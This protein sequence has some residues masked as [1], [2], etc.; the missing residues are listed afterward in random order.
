M[1]IQAQT[2]KLND[3]L[4]IGAVHGD[5]S[6]GV[7]ILKTIAKTRNDF[8]WIIGSPP[9][10]QLNQREF[11]GDLNRSAPGDITS[12]D[13]AKKRAA[14]LITLSKKFRYTIDLHGSTQAVGIF[15]IITKLT[16]QNLRLATMLDV[17]R[18]VLWPALSSEMTGPL[19]EYFPCGVE[20]EC[21][22]KDN[23]AIQKDLQKILET[24]MNKLEEKE[25]LDWKSA[26]Q[27]RKLYK[28]IGPIMH[29][30]ITSPKVLTEFKSTTISGKTISPVFIGSYTYSNIAAYA[31]ESITPQEA[32]T[33]CI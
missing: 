31:L 22:K 18:I 12:N 8:D 1:N 32:L 13:Y 7:D 29:H 28:Q 17:T 19:S 16:A 23:P 21:G 5:E 27:K 20:I 2:K 24:F 3:L 10:L 11:G 14:E 15:I 30:E 33:L 4:F 9:A 6:I 26:L 25:T